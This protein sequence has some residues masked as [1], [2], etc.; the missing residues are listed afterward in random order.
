MSRKLVAT[1]S[2]DLSERMGKAGRQVRQT[3]QDCPPTRLRQY[4]CS[5]SPPTALWH[6][7]WAVGVLLAMDRPQGGGR[8]KARWSVRSGKFRCTKARAPPWGMQATGP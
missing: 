7:P 5:I 8:G 4:L 3:G 6:R 2:D 1:L